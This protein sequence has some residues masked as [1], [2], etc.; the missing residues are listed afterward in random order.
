MTL[1][2]AHVHG[3]VEKKKILHAHFGQVTPVGVVAV[4]HA[5]ELRKNEV[6]LWREKEMMRGK[7]RRDF[8]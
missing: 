5:V 6:D 4:Q 1:N 8:I 3:Q 7:L 2:V